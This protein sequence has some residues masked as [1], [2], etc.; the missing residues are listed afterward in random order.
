VDAEPKRITVRPDSE[1]ALLV[2]GAAAAGRSVVVDTGDETYRLDVSRTSATL[3]RSQLRQ[4]AHRLAGSLA[5]VDIPG[6]ESSEAAEHW[7]DELRE[8]DTFPLQPPTQT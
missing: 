5:D 3:D 8:A 1:I 4:M 2:R 6:W 7:V